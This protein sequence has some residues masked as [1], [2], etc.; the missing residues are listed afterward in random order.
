MATLYTLTSD[1]L[2]L[3]EMMSDSEI[4]EEM[5]LDSIEGVDGEIEA[6]AEGYAMVRAQLKADADA[7]KAEEERLY[8]R[9][10]AIE[11]NVKRLEGS[12]QDAMELTGKTKFKTALFSFGI[13]NNAPSV[14]IDDATAIPEE[15]LI[16]QEPKV[17]K[18]AIKDLLKNG[19]VLSY[20]HLE[21]GK[22]L[23][24]R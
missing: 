9:R 18:T 12:L 8:A 13:Q 17:N 24:I 11:N 6:K 23:R 15:F 19:E 14:V 5:V 16:Q 21:T 20:A 4:D 10:K 2:N 3:Y 22:S 1:W 7:I